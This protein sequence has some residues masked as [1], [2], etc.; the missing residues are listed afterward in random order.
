[1]F[2]L[3]V[4][5]LFI[6]IFLY[7]FCVRVCVC[8]SCLPATP[9]MLE[10]PSLAGPVNEKHCVD[11]AFLHGSSDP[12]SLGGDRVEETSLGVGLSD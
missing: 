3:S 10:A 11:C 9:S 7:L 8:S 5:A 2:L 1:M 12:R 4:S 6:Y